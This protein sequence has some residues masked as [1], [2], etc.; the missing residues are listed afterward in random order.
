MSKPHPRKPKSYL[1]AGVAVL[2]GLAV[3]GARAE[4][5]AAPKTA[6]K[7]VTDE[8]LI[9]PEPENWLSY[10]GNYAGWG[11]SP[12]EQINAE[13]VKRLVPA[14]TLSTGVMD[15]HQSPPIVN[16][17]VMFITTPQAQVLA[18]DAR[19][20]SVIWRYQKELPPELFQLHPT[21]R[22]VGL[23]GDKVYFA[24]TDACVTALDAATGKVA[25]SKCVAKWKE[26]YYIT[27]SPLVAKGKIMVGVSGGEFGIRGFIVGL[28]SESGEEKWKTYTVAGP[29]DP[30]FASWKGEAWK[31]GGAPIW[32]QGNY[33]PTNETAYWG[34]GNGGPWMPD[35]RPGDNLYSTS[36]VAIDV[37][38]GKIK[39]HHQYHY[40]DAWD[41]DEVS[42]PLLIDV[43]KDGRKIPALVHAGRNGYLWTLERTKDGPIKFVDAKPFVYQDAFKSIDPKTGRPTYNE[44]KVPNTGKKAEFCPSLWGGKDWPPEAYNPKTGLLYIPA[45]DNLCADIAGVAVKNRKPGELYIGV[46]VEEILS[47]LHFAKT[48]DVSKPVNIGQLQAWDMNT[49]KKVWQHD[50]MDSATWGPVL[51]TGSGLVFTGGTS[52]RKF[53]A[54]DGKTGK[55][56]WETR[57]NSGVIGV[58]SSYS[59]DGVQYVAVQAGWGVDADRMLG[60]INSH[61]PEERRV[62]LAPQG[63]VVWV[64]KVMNQEAAAK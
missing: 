52:D 27:L 24:S 5:A 51:T 20:G 9:S 55:V 13:N 7:P 16:N 60:G 39:G 61:L 62:R 57:L 46:P 34:T 41:W 32:I 58:P 64:F 22:G 47:S 18:V 38:T 30:G 33:D 63:G 44:D 40:N 3:S 21:N 12:L 59:V 48:V 23:Y 28:D 56:V 42:A 50:F 8:R 36:T 2:A 25:W 31:T 19:D 45:N 14:W 54:F 53:R 4:Q 29:E 35:T 26:G 17:G 15:G 10:R 43:T 49:G 1:L 11:Y 6:Y 37:N